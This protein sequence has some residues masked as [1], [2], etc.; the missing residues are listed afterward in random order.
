MSSHWASKL[1]LAMTPLFARE[2]VETGEHYLLLDGVHGSFGLSKLERLDNDPTP[3]SWAWSSGVLH[4]IT[5]SVDTVMIHRWDRSDIM[6]FRADAVEQQLI[7]FYDLLTQ[8]QTSIARTV[9]DHAV[10]AFRR[11][12]SHFPAAQTEQALS[13]FLLVLAAMV[14]G[15]DEA[16]FEDAGRL[17]EHFQLPDHAPE[18]IRD[19]SRDFVAHLMAGFRRPI[20]PR[21]LDLQTLP[22]LLLR[23]AGTMVFQEAH[24]ETAV[25]GAIDI[26]GVPDAAALKANT[27]NGVHYTPPGLARAL[28]EQAL[29]ALDPLPD[30]LTILDPACGSGSILHEI[31]RTLRDRG[32][33][34]PITVLGFDRSPSAVQ[35][36][37]FF[38]A[39]SKHD[40]LE[41]NIAAITV[42]ERDALSEEAW[43]A[44]HIV[45]MNPPF[46]SLRSL[47]KSQRAS[48][49]RI[50]GEFDKGRPDMAMAFVE[51]ALTSVSAGGVLASL[52]PAGILSMTH[53]KPWRDHL[54]DEATVSLLAAFGEVSLFRMATVE[55]GALVLK[56]AAAVE[57]DTY[58]TL[59]VGEKK[60]DTS[61][62][63]RFLRRIQNQSAGGTEID[64]WSLDERPLR[65]LRQSADWRPRPR[66][67][68]RELA[69]FVALAPVTV[70]DI[71]KVQ[72]G[73]LPAPREAFMI[74]KAAYENLPVTERRWFR[75]VAENRNI[76]SGQILDGEYVFFTRSTKLPRISDED[77]LAD[78]C[79]TFYHHLLPFKPTLSTRRGKAER[80]WELGEDRAWLRTPTIKIVTAYF[81]QA[82]SFAVDTDGDHV[83]VQGYGWT[84]A[85]KTRLPA[86]VSAEAILHAYVAMLNTDIFQKILAEFCPAVGGGQLNLS[87]RF[88]AR[89][90]LPD[91][92]GRA[93][94]ADG[95][96][97]VLRDLTAIGLSIKR[98][99]LPYAPR[100]QAED[101]TRMLYGLR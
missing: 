31:L 23:H 77:A 73:A 94:Q 8:E 87:R 89:V 3:R 88:V 29:L 85:W 54:L 76:R 81:G 90:P 28:A 46:V 58:A 24:F 86:T 19:L 43:P 36:S 35:M 53:A 42:T 16:V 60:D 48:V 92:P 25:Q 6:S 20:L 34:G 55:V 10:D 95:D 37:R 78:A 13:V 82:G 33:R 61:Q 93:L 22:S 17:A 9:T 72:Q 66:F 64:R 63:L 44:S 14:E 65:E 41:L 50:L 59:W 21:S 79:P 97:Q 40:W 11:L 39:L 98:R 2:R 1:G 84:P 32:Y 100:V 99:G 15:R 57:S 30:A 12:R 26:F 56:K 51:R 71:F 5:T 45:V 75:R 38:L 47:T 18:A 96:D 101:L 69:T 4:H 68:Q 80:W 52:L 7:R 74:T 67:L 91:L 62:A 27:S 49:G 83:V 70:D